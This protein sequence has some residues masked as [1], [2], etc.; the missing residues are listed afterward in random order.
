MRHALIILLAL[1][2]LV[3]LS[4]AAGPASAAVAIGAN[5]AEDAFNSVYSADMQRIKAARDPK[6]AVELATRMLATAKESKSQRNSEDAI[7][8][9]WPL[10][11]PRRS[12]N[13][14][15]VL[16][17]QITPDYRAIGRSGRAGGVAPTTGGRDGH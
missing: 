11:F 6:A 9:S 3:F 1:P 15:S 14:K 17:P 10:P 4:P 8:F 7:I 13:G 2:A 12:V 5:P 16:C